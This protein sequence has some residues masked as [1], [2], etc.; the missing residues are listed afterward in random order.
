[1]KCCKTCQTICLPGLIILLCLVTLGGPARGYLIP[2]DALNAG[3]KEGTSGSYRLHDSAGQPVIGDLSTSPSYNHFAGFW[4]A[5]TESTPPCPQWSMPL[6]IICCEATNARTFGVHCSATDN[7]DPGLDTLVPPPGFECYSYFQGVPPFNY[8][9]ADIRSSDS[10]LIE[11]GLVVTNNDPDSSFSVSW[12][13]AD[14]PD[15]GTLTMADSIDM[16]IRNSVTFCCGNLT[17]PIVCG[18]ERDFLLSVLPDTESVECG[19]TAEY[20]VVLTS[21]AGFDVPCSLTVSGTPAGASSLFNPEIVVPTGTSSLRIAT[22]AS[23]P[24]GNYVLTVTARSN[25]L[26]RSED[27]VLIITGE[28]PEWWVPFTVAGMGLSYSRTFGAHCEG[29]DGYDAA[30]DTLIPPPGFD[31]FPYFQGAPPFNYMSADI[32]SSAEC[33]H[34]W[35]LV[36]TN[37]DPDSCV[38]LNWNPLNIPDTICC[39][40]AITGDTVDMRSESSA[41]FCSGNMEI[42][43]VCSCGVGPDFAISAIPSSR[44]ISPGDSTT[45]T[46]TVSSLNG[47]DSAVALSLS[48]L[49]VEASFEFEPD[50]V[51]PTNSSI[52]TIHTG[53]AIDTGTHQLTVT[54]TGGAKTH[55]TQVSLIICGEGWIMP[56]Y[57]TCASSATDSLSYLGVSPS[58]SDLFDADCDIPEPPP[59]PVD[60]VRLYFPHPEWGLMFDEFNSD[61]REPFPCDSSKTWD[62]DVQTDHATQVE[63]SWET[64]QVPLDC[65]IILLDS[66]GG[67]LIPD[68]RTTPNYSYTSGDQTETRSFKIRIGWHWCEAC[69]LLSG[70]WNLISLP[71]EPLNPDPDSV[72]GDDISFY[73]LYGWDNCNFYFPVE[74]VHGCGEAYWLGLLEDDTVCVEGTFCE[75]AAGPIY[76]PLDSCWNALGCPYSTCVDWSKTE[77]CRYGDTVDL[78]TAVASG[79]LFNILYGYREG[80]YVIDPTLCPW[81]GDYIPVLV[82]GCELCVYPQA[83]LRA[84]TRVGTSVFDRNPADGKN[85]WLVRLTACLEDGTSDALS[86]FGV[87]NLA[88]DGLDPQFDIPEPPDLSG[89]TEGVRY[90]GLYFPHPEWKL[91][92]GDYFNWDVKKSLRVGERQVWHLEVE[93]NAAGAVVRLSWHAVEDQIPDGYDLR[94]TDLDGG[95][96]E[97]DMLESNGVAF[98]AGDSGEPRRFMITVTRKSREVSPSTPESFRLWQNHPNPFNPITEINYQIP[99]RCHVRLSIY[100]VAGQLVRNLMDRTQDTGC[101]TVHWEGLDS[102]GEEVASGIYFYRL[103]AGDLE[104]TRKMVL[105]K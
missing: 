10:T 77:V 28:C 3:G 4:Y 25:E 68:V 34:E 8:L 42:G 19:D 54:G 14:L 99:S 104:I 12:S 45:Y 66:G 53:A 60:F 62:F 71:C 36:I 76:I 51:T 7:Y 32:R 52:L 35:T 85:N 81:L 11:W 61:I 92:T 5:V 2:T 50:T 70:G 103:T 86:A 91:T 72:F 41:L 74:E 96:V 65:D 80:G 100:N 93:T 37:N 97:H 43:I 105:L 30:L 22:S 83:P 9:S 20:D 63:L 39:R 23:T 15:S 24:T 56:L 82:G 48:G 73:P 102:G 59:P 49:P 94:L 57:A 98:V 69:T 90:V 13:L 38:T 17:I 40:M 101:Y 64:S 88:S 87:S 21:Q 47:F 6:C 89:A 1:M 95:H 79:W 55:S 16:R 27:I 84:S 29:T 58:C 75:P 67:M 46:V 33:L 78:A 26:V 44:T 31:L 18:F